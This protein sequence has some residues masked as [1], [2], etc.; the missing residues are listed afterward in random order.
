MLDD[1][2]VGPLV[3]AGLEPLRQLSPGRAR[4]TAAGRTA[5]AAAHRVID[6]VHGDA[7]VVGA[8][9]LPAGAAGLAD[10]HAAVLD[11]AH[12]ANGRTA[13]EVNAANLAGGQANLTPVTFLRHQ[14]GAHTGRA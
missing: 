11:V 5:F 3:L 10:V 6:R 14:L 4:V 13:V 9:A 12:L 1:H 8:A 7:A 2:C